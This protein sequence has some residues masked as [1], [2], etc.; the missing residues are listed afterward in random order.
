MECNGIDTYTEQFAPQRVII[1]FCQALT[2]V[3]F[4]GL[5]CLV[6]IL[7]MIGGSSIEN[8]C[9]IF[10]LLELEREFEETVSQE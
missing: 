2:I 1:E 5:G 9:T 3:R 7:R 4:E 6:H 10:V 8:E